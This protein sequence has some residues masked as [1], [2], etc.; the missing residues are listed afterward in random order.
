MIFKGHSKGKKVMALKS[1]KDILISNDPP[2][3]Y[4]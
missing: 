2:E 4:S 3:G 1:G